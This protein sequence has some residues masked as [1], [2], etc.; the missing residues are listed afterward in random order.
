MEQPT[1]ESMADWKHL[2]KG[3]YSRHPYRLRAINLPEGWRLNV[4]CAGWY[5][6]RAAT[7]PAAVAMVEAHA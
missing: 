5:I 2:E 3:V 6:G 7:L 4:Y 1:E